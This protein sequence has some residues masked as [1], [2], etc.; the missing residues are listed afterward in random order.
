MIKGIQAHDTLDPMAEDPQGLLSS[1]GTCYSLG[2]IAELCAQLNSSTFAIDVQLKVLSVT[3]ARAHIDQ[4]HPSVT[5]GGSVNLAKAQAVITATFQPDHQGSLA[6]Q[7]HA[8]YRAFIDGWHCAEY[9][10]TLLTW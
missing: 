4:N 6:F 1:F 9:Q 8:C 7:A 10:D 3:V 5:L 2:Q